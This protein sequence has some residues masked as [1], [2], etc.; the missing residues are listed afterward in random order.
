MIAEANDAANF[1]VNGKMLFNIF[2]SSRFQVLRVKYTIFC[3]R[4]KL[5]AGQL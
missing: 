3:K 2:S 1:T 4:I 5:M